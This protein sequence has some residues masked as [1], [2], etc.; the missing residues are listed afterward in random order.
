MDLINGLQIAI[1]DEEYL[2]PM[3]SCRRENAISLNDCL[4]NRVA[5][6]EAFEAE[7]K[8]RKPGENAS[9]SFS[10]P[11]LPQWLNKDLSRRIV[12]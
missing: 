5:L 11:V 8:S 7:R 6:R 2:D 12:S 10:F 1:Y 9:A 3:G 4:D